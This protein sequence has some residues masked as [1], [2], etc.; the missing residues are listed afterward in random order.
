MKKSNFFH[1]LFA[2]AVLLTGSLALTSCDEATDAPAGTYT[3]DGVFVINE[4]NFGTPNGSVSFYKTTTQEVH[5]DVFS[6][7]NEGRPLGDVVQDMM[8]HD[9]RAYVVAN[10]S[11]KIEVV[12]ASTFKSGG[13]IEGL[14]APRYVAAVNDKAYVTE[15]LPANADYSYNNGR[16]SVIDL[17]TNTV[18]KT[19]TV[20]VQ[21]EHLLISG[22]KVYVTNSGGNTISVINTTTDA[23]EKTIPV[24]FGP[25]SLVLDTNNMLWVLSSGNKD[26][27]LPESAYTAGALSKINISTG[28]V[29]NTFTFPNTTAMADRLVINKTS[30]MLYYNYD[31][32]V[33][34]QSTTAN[35]LSHSMFINKSFYGLSV[36]PAT[37][38]LYGGDANGFKGDGTVYIF[39]PAG[40]QAGTFKAGIAPSGFV[41]N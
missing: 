10:N 22:G 9:N 38:N 23:V 27:A 14:S 12:N 34:Q 8:I 28:T 30:G 25:N 6:K 41:F 5:T 16:V 3:E 24:T 1:R 21:P 11:N 7:E 32:Q 31:G 26:W 15:W 18:L 20:G 36:D 39:T 37:G 35:S 13:V 40:V 2:C 29:V 33:Y 17:K 4:G 19:I